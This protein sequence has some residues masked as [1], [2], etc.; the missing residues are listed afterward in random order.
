MVNYKRALLGTH[1]EDALI[2]AYSEALKTY[3]YNVDLVSPIRQNGILQEGPEEVKQRL[4]DTFLKA[5]HSEYGYDL[6]LMDANLS[7]PGNEPKAVRDFSSNDIVKGRLQKKDLKLI[8]FSGNPRTVEQ[9][10]REGFD[11]VLNVDLVSNLEMF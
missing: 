7:K 11:A 6:V 2:S 3:G 10:K 4:L 5:E 8:C 9:A 1:G